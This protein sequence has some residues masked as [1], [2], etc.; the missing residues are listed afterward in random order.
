MWLP[1]KRIVEKAISG[2]HPSLWKARRALWCF[3]EEF[4]VCELPAARCIWKFPPWCMTALCTKPCQIVLNTKRRH[5]SKCF[6]LE[7]MLFL[8]ISLLYLTSMPVHLGFRRRAWRYLPC[9]WTSLEIWFLFSL[10]P[11]CQNSLDRVKCDVHLP[12]FVDSGREYK[13]DKEMLPNMK[14]L[15]LSC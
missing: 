15:F 2:C 4:C 11:E 14:L 9:Y 5:L 13:R 6:L 3:Q 12:C 7:L 1:S 8:C 10:R